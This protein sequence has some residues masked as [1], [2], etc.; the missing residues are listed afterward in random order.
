M[1]DIV[2]IGGSLAKGTAIAKLL[3]VF[4]ATGLPQRIAVEIITDLLSKTLS[5]LL[6]KDPVDDEA[7]ELTKSLLGEITEA[8]TFS[9]TDKTRFILLEVVTVPADSSRRFSQVTG[10]PD[11]YYFGGASFDYAD[12]T[13]ELP[14][15][16]LLPEVR[17]E[18]IQS[19]VAVPRR[20]KKAKRVHIY[21]VAG[22]E[23]NLWA[24]SES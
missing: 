2:R 15:F 13:D 9:I 4:G 8:G 22:L 3:R 19:L 18:R 24:Y 17:L 23:A 10:Q 1:S 21:P 5:S 7:G 12:S 20:P 14:N 16:S 6:D 11:L